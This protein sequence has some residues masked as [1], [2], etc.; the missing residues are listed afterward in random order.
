MRVRAAFGPF[1][2]GCAGSNII[3]KSVTESRG[4]DFDGVGGKQRREGVGPE[5]TRGRELTTVLTAT[6]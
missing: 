2:R 4:S 3:G 5:G 6:K 1:R